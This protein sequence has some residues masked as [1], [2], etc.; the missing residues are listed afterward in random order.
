MSESTPE[1]THGFS[2]NT[3]AG[4]KHFAGTTQGK[5]TL[6]VGGLVVLYLLYKRVSSPAAATVTASGS[7]ASSGTGSVAGSGTGSTASLPIADQLASWFS[8]AES[9]AVTSSPNDA[10]L[11]D[12]T[13][14]D[15]QNNNP[16]TA[17]E[18]AEWQRILSM[19]GAPPTP[20]G[21]TNADTLPAVPDPIGQVLPSWGIHNPLTHPIAPPD[22]NIAL[23]QQEL[24]TLQSAQGAAG[25]NPLGANAGSPPNANVVAAPA[26]ASY[27]YI[28]TFNGLAP[29]TALFAKDASGNMYHIPNPTALKALPAGTAIF[30]KN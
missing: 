26:Q 15:V 19:A 30:T 3:K 14:S 6:T 22:P 2:P 25:G 11:I 10:A 17:A 20:V 18:Q 13:L 29:G 21:H 8:G 24:L 1:H 9:Q 5:V 16:L 28:S 27:K 4:I 23:I 12:Q 7:P